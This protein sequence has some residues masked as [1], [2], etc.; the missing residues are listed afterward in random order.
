MKDDTYEVI[1]AGSGGQG[2]VSSG[3]M[4]GEA[5]I[6]EG[7]QVMHTTSYGIAQRGGLSSA[8]VIISSAEILFQHVQNPNLILA[9]TDESLNLYLPLASSGVAIFYDTTLVQKH[10]ENNLYGYPFTE[11][12]NQLGHSGVANIIALGAMIGKSKMIKYE[13]MERV[14]RKH[15]SGK[16]AEMNV[17]ALCQGK[18]I[19]EGEKYR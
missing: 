1:L 2:L 4:L 17:K 16:I 9:L 3:I 15:F 10:E 12:A 7:K 5:A 19:G 8:E 6:L 13:S 18:S 14:L 11:M